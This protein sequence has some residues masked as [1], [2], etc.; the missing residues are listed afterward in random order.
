MSSL[1]NIG[2]V[3]ITAGH[4]IEAHKNRRLDGI[5]VLFRVEYSFGFGVLTAMNMK[6]DISWDVTPNILIYVYPHLGGMNL[7]ILFDPEDG[8][9]K[10]LLNFLELPD[11]TT[12]HSEKQQVLLTYLHVLFFR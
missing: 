2:A 8:S 12:T 1:R 9:I 5:S 3:C 7:G 10:C 11:L 4:E 6:S